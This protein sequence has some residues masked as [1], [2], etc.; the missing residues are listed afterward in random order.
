[1]SNNTLT[2]NDIIKS[3]C[4]N[5]GISK[6]DSSDIVDHIIN[7]TID[8][9]ARDGEAKISGFG[10]FYTRQKSARVGRNPKT[11]VSAI[12]TARNVVGFK[13]SNLLKNSINI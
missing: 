1:M 3:I 10:T 2:R 8:G 11:G 6:L 7:M 4:N 5:I 9:I 13:P 12:I